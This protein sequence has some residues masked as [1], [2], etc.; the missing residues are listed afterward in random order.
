MSVTSW[1]S[2]RFFLER[3]PEDRCNELVC[4]LSQKEKEELISAPSSCFDLSS[5]PLTIEQRI[6]RVHYSWFIEF[7]TSINEHDR[8]LII[9]SFDATHREKLRKY[10]HI[11]QSLV[12]INIHGRRYLL[13]ILF[14][15]LTSDQQG[16]VPVEWIPRHPLNALTTLS[17][18]R[19]QM[20]I[21][22]LGLHDLAIEMKR[23]VKTTRITKIHAILTHAQRD[24]LQSLLKG[25]EL[26][27]FIRIHLD[28][29]DG[30]EKQLRD[31]LHHR[32]LN[33]L[34]K[35]LFGSPPSLLWD[36][37]HIL[38]IGRSKILK[39]FFTD[40]SNEY[41]KEL[42]IKQILELIDRVR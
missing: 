41:L 28:R 39:R 33:R 8:L 4:Y 29:W 40:I 15:W 18:D 37:Y 35:A 42:L 9:S 31:I 26:I 25:K 36:V 16:F 2:C 34:A 7:L 20:L 22:Y 27:S 1:I 19:M 21:D 12:P 24:Y 5:I 11:H 30:D 3:I 13:N 23:L 14:H 32:G 10:F 38:D 17:K 6:S